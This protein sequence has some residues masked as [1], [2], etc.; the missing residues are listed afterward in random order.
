MIMKEVNQS[1]DP[2]MENEY[3]S[4]THL[5]MG[6]INTQTDAYIQPNH[7][8]KSDE[9]KCPC[10]SKGV[11]IRQGEVRRHHFAH[12]RSEN[13]CAY[14]SSPSESQI[15]KDAKML[16]KDLLERKIPIRITRPCTS[17]NNLDI[18]DIPEITSTSRIYPDANGKEYTFR[19]NESPKSAD[20]AYIDCDKI[21]YIFEICHTHKTHEED[22]PEPW[23]EIDAT[24]LHNLVGDY[25]HKGT[26]D[27]PCIRCKTCKPCIWTR[28]V[29]KLQQCI[30]TELELKQQ[31]ER[32]EKETQQRIQ[33]ELERIQQQEKDEKETQQRIQKELELKQQ[34]EQAEKEL[35]TKLSEKNRKCISCG[36]NYCKCEQPTFIKYEYNNKLVCTSCRQYRCSCM[37][38]TEF[39]KT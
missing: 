17:C 29:R 3:K 38:I 1:T 6:A 2:K 8:T 23:V 33:K 21:V 35:I 4:M 10:C 26:L 7:A 28:L 36:V 25:K 20:V 32:V 37:K 5:S 12:T 31:Q 34:Q 9:Y 22:R 14:Y 18:F 11:F 15:H 24:G 19:Y 39:F 13:P 27:I 30:R 16:M